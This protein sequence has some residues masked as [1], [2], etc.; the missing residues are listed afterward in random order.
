[1]IILV[2]TMSDRIIV[3]MSG[4]VDSS[5][6]AAILK[7]EGFDVVGVTFDFGIHCKNRDIEFAASVA[8]KLG[9]EYHVVKRE[10]KFKENV[11]DYFIKSYA[12]GNSPNPCVQCNRN[13]KFDELLRFSDDIGI[14][15]IATGHYARTAEVEGCKRLFRGLDSTRDQSYFLSMLS[16]EQLNRLHFPLAS[17]YTKDETKDCA[18]KY[19]LVDI[20]EK[21]SSQDICFLNTKDNQYTNHKELLLAAIG[22]KCGDIIHKNGTL[23]GQHNGISNFTIGQ[24]KG[25]NISHSDPLYV[26]K[27]DAKTNVVTVGREDDLYGSTMNV[28]ALSFLGCSFNIGDSIVCRVKLRSTGPEAECKLTILP[29]LR[30]IVEF[31]KPMRAITKG[32]C[33]AFYDNDMVVGGAWIV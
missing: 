4:G 28:E 7:N 17:F 12:E 3:A 27:I 14:A 1:M 15:K 23:L 9:I 25:I 31:K 21:R 11:I 20:A 26:L 30:G 19:G 16:T 6:S 13:V 5:V 22:K 29:N 32:Q 18:M 33:A 8:S 10:K 24:R 2:L